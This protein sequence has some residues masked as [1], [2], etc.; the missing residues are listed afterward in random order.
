MAE[1]AQ[2]VPLSGVT[3]RLR[4]HHSH[5]RRRQ[6]NHQTQSWRRGCWDI[7]LILVSHCQL[8]PS[9]SQM[10]STV[11][12]LLHCFQRQKWHVLMSLTMNLLFVSHFWSSVWFSFT[13]WNSCQSQLHPES[14]A[15][16]LCSRAHWS[17][18]AHLCL[19]FFYIVLLS[20]GI[21][22]PHK[23]MGH[24][25]VWG[26]C[27][28]E[29]SEEK[30]RRSNPPQK[31][32]RLLALTAELCLSPAHFLHLSDTGFLHSAFGAFGIGEWRREEGQEQQKSNISPGHGDRES[33][34]PT[35]H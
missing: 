1:A 2:R 5:L 19:L 24:D 11:W 7:S 28:T 9:P 34:E 32:S 29:W 13:V 4:L 17:P 20:R 21:G 14:A 22:G 12:V 33:P 16:I 18:T 26:G 35:V 23:T 25:R 3:A 30:S 8:T 27:P 6:K 31:S 15:K 10:N